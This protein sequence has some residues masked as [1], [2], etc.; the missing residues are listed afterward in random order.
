MLNIEEDSNFF[1]EN[2]TKE[3]RELYD[4]QFRLEGWSQEILKN[5]RVL[6]VGVGGLG[7]EIAK[8]LAMVGV[9]HIDLVDLDIIEHS[10]LNRQLLFI[11]AEMGE[12]KATAAAKMLK[13]INPN[14]TIKGYA[15]SLERL[16]P[17][18]YEKADVI[19]GGLDSMNARLNLNAQ[20]VRFKK[21]LID[22]GVSGYHGHIYTIFPYENAC[23]ECY[24]TP[25]AEMDD[26][27]ACT[28]VGIPRKRV[29][30]VFKAN[31]AFEEKFES[32]PDPKDK[33]DIQFLQ[34][35][36]NALVEKHNFFPLFKKEEIVKI[37]DQHDPGIITINSIIASYQSHET[38]KILHWLAG[39]TGLGEPLKDYIVMNAMTMKN[40]SIEKKRNFECFQCGENVKRE[41]I[42]IQAGN[43]CQEIIEILKNKGYTEDPYM[44]PL[45]TVMD[46]N[47]IREIDLEKDLEENRVRDLEL[48]TAAGFKE[49]EIFI[50]LNIL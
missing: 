1:S 14:I 4:R 23:Y 37:L 30:C 48:L 6:I 9:G 28:V 43:K 22:G 25:V 41:V 5:S 8:N 33:E 13:K 29:H 27:A 26:M 3:E 20:C 2:L 39:K 31:M 47:T 45:I 36:A 38:I 34:K 24:P 18:L 15:S 19:I 42:K 10:N 40:Y 35:E 12:P 16:T 46:F 50:T 32:Q 7:C 44:E 11:N 17:E 49:G 21:P